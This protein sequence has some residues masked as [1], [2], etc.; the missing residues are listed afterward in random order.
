MSSYDHDIEMPDVDFQDRR[1]LR[2]WLETKDHAEAIAT[3]LRPRVHFF[4]VQLQ[5]YIEGAASYS[6]SDLPTWLAERFKSVSADLPTL[7]ALDTL[8]E[9]SDDGDFVE[10][11]IMKL[12]H[13][14]HS[15][16]SSSTL[17]KSAILYA[18]AFG[19]ILD[20]NA[21]NSSSDSKAQFLH[22][23]FSNAYQGD[24]DR[25]FCE[26]IQDGYSK[27]YRSSMHYGRVIA[28]LQG[29]STGKS[30]LHYRVGETKIPTFTL[31][32]RRYHDE[33]I[34]PTQGWPYGDRAV[35]DFFT[36]NANFSAS[37]EQMAAAFLGQLYKAL[38]KTAQTGVGCFTHLAPG[39]DKRAITNRD[40]FLTSVCHEAR[41]ELKRS[42]QSSKLSTTT[43]SVRCANFYG[44]FVTQHSEEL[45]KTLGSR[46]LYS[47]VD[48]LLVIDECAELD[49][50]GAQDLNNADTD[51]ASF[52]TALR[53][54]FKAG[55]DVGASKTFW[56]VLLDTHSETY[57]L[58]PVTEERA[59]SARLME[60]TYDPLPPW[61]DLGFDVN[62]DSLPT[63]PHD[64]L[65]LEW[66]KKCGRPYW[67]TLA[68]P[69]VVGEG[70]AKLFCGR[71]D[72]TDDNHI[73]AAISR[74][75]HL[76]LSHDSSNTRIHLT[77]V[78]RHMRYMQSIGWE[79][80][81]VT[82]AAMSEPVLSIA[83]A[84]T[85]LSD[86]P[87]YKKIIER[88]VDSVLVNE[89]IIELLLLA[90]TH[91]TALFFLLPANV[92]VRPITVNA[93]FQSLLGTIPPSF[94][95]WAA[96]AYLSFTHIDVLP[97]ILSGTIPASLLRF[98]WCRGVG[99]H[100]AAN[101]PIYD[102]I[103][104]VYCGNLHKPFEDSQFTYLII[105]VKAKTTVAVK[106]LL[107]ALTGPPINVD[108][109]SHKPEHVVLLMDLGANSKFHDRK[110]VRMG[111]EPAVVPSKSTNATV[112]SHYMS[113]EPNRWFFHARGT[114]DATYPSLPLF[115]ADNLSKAL[116]LRR[117]ANDDNDGRDVV[118]AAAVRWSSAT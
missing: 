25:R 21:S 24:A 23:A 22:A 52:L 60:G 88:F 71:V 65:Q 81:I 89:H 70:A 17:S 63:I 57:M 29:S 49:K 98:G 12:W 103:I 117:D 34:D 59:S 112:I 37:S 82:T 54:I 19:V 85:M 42:Q 77:A 5:G 26:A 64:A 51:S 66:L 107:E 101:Q 67:H 45:G 86:P 95:T 100:C 72:A 113:S 91:M 9:E 110:L 69:G 36:P 83:A 97:E 28:M 2:E 6:N 4:P 99:F 53:R 56:M 78:E 18:F 111:R 90:P 109:Q 58:Y 41:Q 74:R 48:F 30:R 75:I 84:F 8:S 106:S 15:R 44:T 114:T 79:D 31:C 13:G 50:L 16:H 39:A 116:N 61:I 92:M 33:R 43:S 10:E 102:I 32:F 20:Y 7:V 94:Q 35:V 38:A 73:I 105:Q 27:W 47:C 96:T 104:P 14:G 1:K 68:N 118:R 76:P 11:I 93:F 46:S 87:T 80:G 40:T 55:D 115:G 3:W 62:L 108:G